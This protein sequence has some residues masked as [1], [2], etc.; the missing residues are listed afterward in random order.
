M[1][2]AKVV[3]DADEAVAGIE[4][5]ST[6]LVGGFGEVGVPTSLISALVRLGVK[7]L[8]LVSNNC[9]SGT[10]G[11]AELFRHRM[12]R[13][14]TVS[15]PLQRGNDDFMAAYREGSVE[16]EI[17]PQGTLA[18]R[19]QA[20]GAGIGGFY[21]PAGVGTALARDRE[22]RTIDGREYLLELPLAGDVAL[23]RA[24]QADGMG[25]L[26]FR[27]SARNFNPV[28][29]RAAALTVV[30]ASRVVAV[31]AI[32]PDDVHTSGI[33]VDRVVETGGGHG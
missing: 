33:Y 28:M 24:H 22:M 32:D 9:G 12:V 21:T 7:D 20:A 17:V 2:A 19:L 8:T 15:F 30:E 11:V 25:N 3:G 1:T 14:A 18:A 27:R 4:D 13:K 5:G 23:I 16:L 10:L 29:A 31:G 26:R 6:I